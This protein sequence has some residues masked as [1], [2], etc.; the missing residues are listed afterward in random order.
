M[1]SRGDLDGRDFLPQ[2]THKGKTR[3]VMKKAKETKI[4]AFQKNEVRVMTDVR[5]SETIQLSS[6][7]WNRKAM[8]SRVKPL[9]KCNSMDRGSALGYRS[10][11]D[12]YHCS[13]LRW[14]F[15]S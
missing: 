12:C 10:D 8:K 3:L 5:A 2:F 14:T 9:R 7:L 6:I 13:V 1:Y 15:Q 11:S 4:E